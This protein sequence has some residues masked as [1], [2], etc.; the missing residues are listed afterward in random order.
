M[1]RVTTLMLRYAAAAY[2]ITRAMPPAPF[3]AMPRYFDAAVSR[4]LPP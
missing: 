4:L 2:D 3:R 1:L